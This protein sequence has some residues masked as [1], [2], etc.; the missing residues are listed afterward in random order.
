M[1]RRPFAWL[2]VILPALAGC[3]H[4][5]LVPRVDGCVWRPVDEFPDD[6]QALVYV[7]LIDE[8]GGE[9]APLRDHLLQLGF[10]NTVLGK[11]AQAG[12]LMVEMGVAQADQ[13]TGRFAIIGYGSGVDGARRLAAFAARM[14]IPLDVTFYIE[15]ATAE[16]P[17]PLDPARGCFTIRAR[18]LSCPPG[19][20]G[21]CKPVQKADVPMHSQTLG[22]VERE[23]TLM[24]MA[25][26]PPRKP[27]PVRVHL[28]PP[29]PPPRETTPRPKALSLDWLFLRLS[30]PAAPPEPRQPPDMEALPMP[31]VV[32]ELPVPTPT[33]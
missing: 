6:A 12:D 8:G 5:R 3:A 4:D 29:M 2:I 19:T 21:H 32:P 24:T 30:H 20:V 9:L 18:D 31:R 28:V 26:I 22:L 14:G 11:P 10:R 17:G 7:F 1:P 33:S 23:L 15:P 16:P 13:P 25:V 27:L